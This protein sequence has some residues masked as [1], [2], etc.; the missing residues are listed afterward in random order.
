MHSFCLLEVPCFELYF[1]VAKCFF[2]ITIHFISQD[3]MGK[4]SPLVIV[5]LVL[6]VPMLFIYGSK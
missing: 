5:M 1:D 2:K 4:R 3:L 6:S